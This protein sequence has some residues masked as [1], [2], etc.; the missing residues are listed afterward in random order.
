MHQCLVFSALRY[1]NSVVKQVGFTK[2]SIKCAFLKIL[3]CK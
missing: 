1:V 2:T 3:T